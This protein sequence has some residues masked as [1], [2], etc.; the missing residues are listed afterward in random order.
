ML[1]RKGFSL[2][3]SHTLGLIL[4]VMGLLVGVQAIMNIN[5]TTLD[6]NANKID[7]AI[8][9]LGGSE[10]I[11][12]GSL[13]NVDA[14]KGSVDPVIRKQNASK[15]MRG[16]IAFNM[17]AAA[18]C[19]IIRA[20]RYSTIKDDARVRHFDGFHYAINQTEF[21]GN[22]FGANA[23]DINP[24]DEYVKN[25]L[26]FWTPDASEPSNDEEGRYGRIRYK[27]N[28]TFHL[29]DTKKCETE[30]VADQDCDDILMSTNFHRYNGIGPANNPDFATGARFSVFIPGGS[31]DEQIYFTFDGDASDWEQEDHELF[32]D[33]YPNN[34]VDEYDSSCDGAL[35]CL[36]SRFD[37]YSQKTL[38]TLQENLDVLGFGED[39]VEGLGLLYEGGE[40][41][42]GKANDWT[43][44][45]MDNEKVENNGKLN[46]YRVRMKGVPAITKA[47]PKYEA[48]EGEG[49]SADQGRYE[50]FVEAVKW[51]FCEGSEGYI[52]S[53][54]KH[55]VNTGDAR[56][57]DS[58]KE[59]AV[60][61]AVYLTSGN[62]TDCIPR[63]KEENGGNNEHFLGYK[64]SGETCSISDADN[65]EKYDLEVGSEE[66]TAECAFMK[67]EEGFGRF[68]GTQTV[69]RPGFYTNSSTS[70]CTPQGGEIEDEIIGG[71]S[72]G[73]FAHD[74]SQGEIAVGGDG[75]IMIS[76][77][78][79]GGPTVAKFRSDQHT[80]DRLE[81]D[82]TVSSAK[83]SDNNKID[84][85]VMYIN[86]WGIGGKP[87]AKINLAR[88]S[89]RPGPD[90]YT[91]FGTKNNLDEK[92]EEHGFYR[93]DSTVS[94]E[95]HFD[96][97]VDDQEDPE[98]SLEHALGKTSSS[99]FS[100]QGDKHGIYGGRIEIRNRDSP[101][102][103]AE[104]DAKYEITCK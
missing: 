35:D 29:G 3:F 90:Y 11:T 48:D 73:G 70:P 28:E 64:L 68:E 32:N 20:V 25:N 94:V 57:Q 2:P 54:A 12:V 22:C 23:I 95:Q 26:K 83:E 86:L 80:W 31:P 81:M 61:P 91:E 76:F 45:W 18:N 67:T 21:S 27:V 102:V 63:G 56:G 51:R 75:F 40:T 55:Q 104:I 72:D 8:A 103:N 7:E 88:R 1:N 14:D 89:P 85:G 43:V 24:V 19:D 53:N 69:Y 30:E 44:D 34:L 17:L 33:E 99:E 66:L 15:Q 5:A 47:M 77:T 78:D 82:I 52:Q 9:S 10:T 79:Q 74:S 16:L 65:R 92:T 87:D 101:A 13:E 58:I 50:D 97:T 84:P 41:L 96:L 39:E 49:G 37:E 6:P 93:D 38:G 59:D 36:S 62:I 71:Y 4:G 60:Y 98:L 46:Y 42:G 100:S